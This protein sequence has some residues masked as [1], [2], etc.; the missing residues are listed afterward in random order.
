M[1]LPRGW[2]AIELD[3]SVGDQGGALSGGQA[4]KLE[5]ARVI[6]V[7]TPCLILDE[8]SSALDPASEFRI[9]RDVRDAIGSKTTLIAVVHNVALAEA[10]DQVIWM[11][12]GTVAG[13]G[14]GHEELL[15]RFEDYRSL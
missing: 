5:F 9:F 13:V 10:A 15:K 11:N 7:G 8:S 2:T 12:A 14:G 4:Q 6:G 1:E 3:A